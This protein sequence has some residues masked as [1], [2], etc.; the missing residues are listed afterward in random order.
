LENLE[1]GAGG[2][3]RLN[4]PFGLLRVDFGVPLT[5][6]PRQSSGRWYFGIGHAF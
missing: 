4:S 1:A 3:L 5:N 2:G 6:R